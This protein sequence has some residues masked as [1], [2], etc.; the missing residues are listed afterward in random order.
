MVILQKDCGVPIQT[1]DNSDKWRSWFS[2]RGGMKTQ[3]L[4]TCF[5]AL[6]SIALTKPEFSSPNQLLDSFLKWEPWISSH[7]GM[8]TRHLK[9]DRW[10]LSQIAYPNP[11]S[12]ALTNY[13]NATRNWSTGL[14]SHGGIQNSVHGNLPLT[15]RSNSLHQTRI[16]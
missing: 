6:R 7:G 1:S 11:K 10:A 5:W 2:S 15:T 8:K 14:L 16:L 3:Q 9:T 4:K 13:W 12:V